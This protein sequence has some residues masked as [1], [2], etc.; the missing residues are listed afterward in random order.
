LE[1]ERNKIAIFLDKIK[2]IAQDGE[3]EYSSV[4][5]NQ[6]E[7]T[8]KDFK[9]W[10]SEVKQQD[11]EYPDGWNRAWRNYRIEYLG[12]LIEQ[13]NAELKEVKK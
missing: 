6:D 2:R 13:E 4:W 1:Q 3:T 11:W 7:E 10:V 12:F 8:Q 5:D 9:S